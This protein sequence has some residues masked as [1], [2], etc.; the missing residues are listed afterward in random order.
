MTKHPSI[1]DEL[2]QLGSGARFIPTIADMLE[3]ADMFLELTR[4]EVEVIANYVQAY[5]APPGSTV[6]REG[7]KECYMF[8][9]AEG[10][11]DIYKN[12]A[13]YKSEKKL[14]TVRAGK[15]IG[16]MSLIDG[17]PHSATAIVSEPAKLLLITYSNFE[18]LTQEHPE[19]SLRLIRK[20]A[21]LMSLRLRQT[22]GILVD[23]I[24]N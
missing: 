12:G 2:E 4:H 5:S 24:Q 19:L 14:A 9:I 13:D 15:T 6:L 16:E 7:G 17:M 8:I 21:T 3:R 10:K 23:Y 20:I 1:F 11:V 22:S 18:K